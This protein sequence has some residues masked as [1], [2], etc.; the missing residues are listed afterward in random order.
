ME[1]ANWCKIHI[2]D[3]ELRI[4]IFKDWGMGVKD[5]ELGKINMGKTPNPKSKSPIGSFIT[6]R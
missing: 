1:I 3:F 5:R 4:G 2:G 6:N